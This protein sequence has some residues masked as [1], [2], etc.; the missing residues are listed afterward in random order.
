MC[1]ILF[2]NVA[3]QLAA[4]SGKTAGEAFDMIRRHMSGLPVLTD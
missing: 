1:L 2:Y 3:L 4:E